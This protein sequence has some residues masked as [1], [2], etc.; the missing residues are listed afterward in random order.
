VVDGTA[1]DDERLASSAASV[2]VK[3]ITPA[4]EGT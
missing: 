2:R 3:P 4:F 1:V